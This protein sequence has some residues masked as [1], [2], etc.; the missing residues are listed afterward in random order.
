MVLASELAALGQVLLIDLVLAGDNAIVVGLVAARLPKEQRA[1]VI[2]I[3]ILAA[4]IM[5]ILFAVGTSQLLQII[6]LTLA[7][8]VL[9]LWV[10]WKLWRE[11]AAAN[12]QDEEASDPESGQ[13][14][15]QTKS[16]RQAIIQIVLADISMSLDNV[17][18]V[19]GAAQE[20]T[21]VLIV[22]LTLSVAFMGIAASVIARVLKKY[23]WLAYVGL[24][25]ILYVAIKMIWE[26]W[27][28]VFHF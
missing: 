7:G 5:R 23:H 26:G 16:M 9:L 28:Q 14:L 8:G 3:G 11:I 13:L 4:T 1:K 24:V 6:G 20:H 27:E 2:M 17:L 18:A 19:A 10:C 12:K 25:T 21:W 22:G 15:K